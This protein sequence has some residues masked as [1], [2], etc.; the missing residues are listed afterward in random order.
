MAGSPTELQAA[1]H[2]Q[3]QFRAL[4]YQS[5]LHAFNTR[6][7]Y[8]APGERVDWRRITASSTIAAKAGLAGQGEI[9]VIAHLDIYLPRDDRDLNHNL[10]GLTLQGVDDNAAG[11]GMWGGNHF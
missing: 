6:Y 7:R 11:L 10:G 4:G 9:L 3:Q 5:D 8:G 1:E 2:L